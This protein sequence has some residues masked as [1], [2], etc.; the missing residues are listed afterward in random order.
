MEK[1]SRVS[2]FQRRFTMGAAALLASWALAFSPGEAVGQEIWAKVVDATNDRPIR[3]AEVQVLYTWGELVRAGVTDANGRV[4]LNLRQPGGYR[5]AVDR[6]GYPASDTL[7]VHIEVGQTITVQ[8]RLQPEAIELDG[9]TVTAERINWGLE[10]VGFYNRQR[11]STGYFAEVPGDVSRRTYQTADY[12][13]GMRGIT[14]RNG[15]PLLARG[16]NLQIWDF[17]GN[18][19]QNTS[20]TRGDN[21]LPG[22]GR[23]ERGSQTNFMDVSGTHVCHGLLVVDGLISGSAA[24]L[25][26]LVNPQDVAAIEMHPNTASAPPQWRVDLA[27]RG[28]AACGVFVVWTKRGNRGGP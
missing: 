17:V 11:G 7:A 8:I 21:A 14:V 4:Y 19:A 18:Q 12:F 10:M 3:D 6:L 1:A 13:R 15:E 27:G 26:R 5:L 28:S 2:R 9:L 25:N 16:Q 22:T 20:Q 24:E 23:D